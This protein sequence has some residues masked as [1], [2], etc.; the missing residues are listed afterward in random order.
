MKVQG[1]KFVPVYAEPGK[2]WVCF[3]LSDPNVDNPVNKS[4]APG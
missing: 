1:G 4:F 3:K 2:P